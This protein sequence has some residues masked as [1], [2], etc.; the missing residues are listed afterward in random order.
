MEQTESL[1]RGYLSL[2]ARARGIYEYKSSINSEFLV[3]G[4]VAY[5]YHPHAES[6]RWSFRGKINFNKLRIAM[7]QW[8]E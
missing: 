7:K 2:G 3:E 8:D 1:Q 6:K 5:Y 4:H